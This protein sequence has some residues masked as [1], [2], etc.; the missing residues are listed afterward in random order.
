MVI[1]NEHIGDL[2]REKFQHDASGNLAVNTIIGGGTVTLSGLSVGGIIT[3]VNLDDTQWKPL[4]AT[5]LSGR[6][7]IL[8]Q[9]ISGNTG[10]VLWNYSAVA[11]AT[12]GPR[13][14]D[15]G[16]KSAVLT[17]DIIIYGRMLSGSGTVAIDEVA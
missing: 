7:S 8:V 16:F 2:E 17:D 4:P 11:P 1:N 10:V 14:E 6:N 12:E 13:I 3:H 15:G 5:P 9:N